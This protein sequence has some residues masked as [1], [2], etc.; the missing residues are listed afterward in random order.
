MGG[1]GNVWTD[2]EAALDLGEYQGCVACNDIGAAYPGHLDAWVSLHPENFAH[3][4][5]ARAKAG[6]VQPGR[7]LTHLEANGRRVEP[8]YTTERTQFRFPGQR[9]SGSSGLFALKVALIDLG[10]DRAVLC[11]VPMTAAAGHFFDL[12]T[13]QGAQS[14]RRGW[15]E[16]MPHIK[17]R[18]RSLSG[19]TQEILGSPDETWLGQ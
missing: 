1:A 2:L 3:W 7:L 13:W 8:A 9:E 10:F 18:A 6:H 5:A 11:G 14:H 17:D 19:W 12:A 15:Q 4:T 16:A